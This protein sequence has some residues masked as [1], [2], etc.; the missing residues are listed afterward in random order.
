MTHRGFSLSGPAVHPSPDTFPN[1]A[2]SMLTGQYIPS[3]SISL[4]S[5]MC[6]TSISLNFPTYYAHT[7]VCEGSPCEE[8]PAAGGATGSHESQRRR[9]QIHTYIVHPTLLHF[10]A[11]LSLYSILCD[12]CDVLSWKPEVGIVDNDTERTT[13]MNENAATETASH[14]HV[15]ILTLEIASSTQPY[16]LFF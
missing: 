5:C 2:P 6:S 1:F 4:W 13:L 12:E 14:P 7:H 10:C 3:T 11:N 15:T 16:F 8:R 9:H